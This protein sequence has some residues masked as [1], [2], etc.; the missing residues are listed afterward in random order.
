[1]AIVLKM[2]IDVEPQIRNALT[3]F[4]CISMLWALESIS[5]IV[6]ALLIP[7][8]SVVLGISG[9]ENPF[10]GF[11]NP[12]I[13]LLLSGLIIAQA[14]RKSELDK[15]I[16]VKVLSL[17]KGRL[18]MLL[19]YLM[20]VTAI[21]GMWMSNT[22]TIALLIPV[23]LTIS[24]EVGHNGGKD[25]TSMFLLSAGFASSIGGL[26]SIL[27]GNANAITASF[28]RTSTQ[29]D[30]LDWFVIGFPI[31]VVLFIIL[32]FTMLKI[33]R[34]DDE[35]IDIGIIK[36][37]AQKTRFTYNQRK[38]L[39]IFIPTIFLWLF[40]GQ[41]S[42]FFN[43]PPAFYRTEIIGL[44]AA[45][46]LFSFRVLEWDDV[47][48]IP[49]EI[50]LLV[51]G[52]LTL[53][54][55]FIDTGTASLLAD[56]LFASIYWMPIFIVILVIVIIAMVLANFVNNSSATIILVPVLMEIS[57]HFD[58]SQRLLVMTAAMAT[59]AAAL[60]PIAMPSF[61][62]IY[63]T[64]KVERGEMVKTGLSVALICAPVLAIMITLMNFFIS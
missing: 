26:A 50:F 36:E 27:G 5:M 3:L 40:G 28:L 21:F 10:I 12:M 7:V 53:G 41:I 32:Y 18:K 37:A 6:T 34:L 22:A 25:H 64:G 57:Q 43:I 51:G 14:F 19:F 1:M 63:G 49:W 54:Q 11:S 2:P 8:L 47:R 33:Y 58:I 52:G 24:G 42:S 23:I 17:S 38:L 30:F 29:F 46:L 4:I 48:R 55:V 31:S 60:T 62:L 16:A 45:I 56:K 35:K 13:Y 9:G 39:M 59:A 15:L 44:S 61:S 20:F